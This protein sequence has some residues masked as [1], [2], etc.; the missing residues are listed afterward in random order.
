MSEILKIEGSPQVT[1]DLVESDL[2]SFLNHNLELS[3]PDQHGANSVDPVKVDEIVASI[4]QE[5]GEI[6]VQ[7]SY[8]SGNLVSG[9]HKVMQYFYPQ[10]L[11]ESLAQIIPAKIPENLVINSGEEI[12]TLVRRN[13]RV[14][15]GRSEPMLFIDSSNVVELPS[16]LMSWEVTLLSTLAIFYLGDGDRFF[17]EFTGLNSEYLLLAG[18]IAL[19]GLYSPEILNWLSGNS[20]ELEA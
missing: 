15:D 16:W 2:R 1:R 20:E 10:G 19:I 12:S 11:V 13:F 7:V 3:V 9:S 5:L 18:V 17:E 8:V 4:L 6:E 14:D